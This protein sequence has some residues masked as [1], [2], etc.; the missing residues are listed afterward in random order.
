MATFSVD[1]TDVVFAGARTGHKDITITGMPAGGVTVSLIGSSRTYFTYT[2]NPE[3]KGTNVYRVSTKSTNKSSGGSDRTAGLRIVNKSDSTDY[4]TVSLTQI[5]NRG[6]DNVYTGSSSYSDIYTTS[7]G[8]GFFPYSLS[9]STG[10]I[11]V[12]VDG[13]TEYTK[14]D[15]WVSV[16]AETTYTDTGFKKLLV[17]CN[18]NYDGPRVGNIYLG[19][20]SADYADEIKIFQNGYPSSTSGCTQSLSFLKSGGTQIIELKIPS[21]ENVLNVTATQ[22]LSSFNS[23]S[24][25]RVSDTRLNFSLTVGNNNTGSDLR[26]LVSFN[27][28][29]ASNYAY[30]GHTIITQAGAEAKSLTISP[31]GASVGSAAGT[32]TVTVTSTGIDT[33]ECSIEEG[34][35]SLKTQSS[36]V[37]TFS[38]T[39]N[40]TSSKRSCI[41]TFYGGGLSKT[42]VI[43]QAAGAISVSP[44]SQN[45]DNTSGTIQV[46]VTGSSNITYSISGSWLTYQSKSGNVYT[47]AYIQNSTSSQRTATV[48]FSASNMTDGVFT[49]TQAGASTDELTATPSSLNFTKSGGEKSIVLTYT[50][51]LHL[52]DDNPGWITDISYSV[53]SSPKTYNITAAAN[54]SSY[55]REWKAYF[56]DANSSIYVPIIQNGTTT[57]SLNISPTSGNVDENSGRISITVTATGINSSD[58]NYQISGSWLSYSSRSG[59]T[60]YFEYP[61]N[62]SSRSRTATITFSAFGKTATYTLVQ[63]AVVLPDVP[64]SFKVYPK[65]LRYYGEGGSI[66]VSFT[67]RP[68]GGIDYEITYIDGSDWLIVGDSGPNKYVSATKNSGIRRRASIRFYDVNDTKNYVIVKVIQGN[69]DGYNS[70]WMDDLYY[71]ESR[72]DNGNYYYRLVNQKNNAEYFEGVSTKPTN[73]GGEI[74]G[75]DIPRLIDEHLHS[76]LLSGSLSDWSD[77]KESYITVDIY[78]MTENGYP[79]VVDATFKYYNDWSRFEKRYDYTRSLNDPINGK[80]CDNMIIPFCVYYDDAA[81]FSIVDT[82][83]NGNVNTYTLSKPSTPFAMRTNSF[84]D[85]KKLEYKQDNEVIFSYDMDHCGP[86]AFIYRNRFGGWDSFLIEG[87]IIKTDNYTKL[88]W[89]RKGEYNQGYSINTLKYIDEKVTDSVNID[90]T[91]QAYTGWLS[92]EEAERL[93]FHL[94]SS[95]IVYFQNL[96]KENQVF[97]TDPLLDLI[98]IRITTSSAEY[99]KFRNGKKLVNYLITFEKSNTEKVRD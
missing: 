42:F 59:Y 45:V 18:N 77:M 6:K 96:H 35:V 31:T 22:E 50:G 56:Y 98:P 57:P 64:G 52:R 86:G 40:T 20:N 62:K 21:Q 26:G 95:P 78:N 49:L 10:H 25:E 51:T 93:V 9:D 53:G 3:S 13:Y 34:W 82:E 30:L 94:L 74:G 84:Y 81:T 43:N 58:I 29:S 39:A 27:A 36:N 68:E 16:V 38:Y 33:V 32:T 71:P 24:I 55:A 89:R 83:K 65:K 2:N 97:D 46:T 79:G 85:T 72:D 90:T 15:S 73:W 91:Y 4:V 99:K 61:E 5:Y 28:G 69:I 60:F 48:T 54:T 80:G 44:K 63:S 11:E 87:N 47:F 92:D 41:I 19:G 37:Y 17:S 8:W 67:N 66:R 1:I 70:I 7:S 76:L 14:E 12:L 23:P 75:I 88:N